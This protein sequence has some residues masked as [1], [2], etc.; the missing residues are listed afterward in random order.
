MPLKALERS[1]V[2]KHCQVHESSKQNDRGSLFL[3]PWISATWANTTNAN[4]WIPLKASYRMRGVGYCVAMAWATSPVSPRHVE[5]CRSH[6]RWTQARTAVDCSIVAVLKSVRG[7]RKAPAEPEGPP[8][9]RVAVEG[10][11]ENPLRS[12][13]RF[14]LE[15]SKDHSFCENPGNSLHR[16]LKPDQIMWHQPRATCLIS[17]YLVVS[18]AFNRYSTFDD[19]VYPVKT[20]TT[21]KYVANTEPSY[22]R[23]LLHLGKRVIG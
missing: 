9:P 1:L 20:L 10:R 12:S 13:V 3:I 19:S 4:D 2:G 6:V 17:V 15:M 11:K 7:N 22:P 23:Q 14:S 21:V 5:S 8:A 18:G 16:R